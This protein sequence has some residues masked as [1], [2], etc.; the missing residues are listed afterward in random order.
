M[1]RR[2]FGGVN[3]DDGVALA[4]DEEF[5]LLFVDARPE[6]RAAFCIEDHIRLRLTDADVAGCL[7]GAR[8]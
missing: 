6:A 7:M 5:A 3:L 1:K 2:P 4:S 8:F